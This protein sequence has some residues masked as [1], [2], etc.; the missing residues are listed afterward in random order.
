MAKLT[1]Q[2]KKYRAW[3]LDTSKNLLEWLDEHM[4]SIIEMNEE[5]EKFTIQEIGER[6]AN[7]PVQFSPE[8]TLTEDLNHTRFDTAQ[9]N[10]MRKAIAVT[11]GNLRGLGFIV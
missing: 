6:G 3:T 8:I 7:A 2:Q 1:K 10:A 11:K 9:A 5:S 4:A